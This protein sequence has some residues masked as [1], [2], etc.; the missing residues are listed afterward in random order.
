MQPLDLATLFHKTYERLA[1][2]FGYETRPET[3]EFNPES[4][5][6]K[7]MIAVCTE[8]LK[9]LEVDY[10]LIDDVITD[11]YRDAGDSDTSQACARCNVRRLAEAVG[12]PLENYRLLKEHGPQRFLFRK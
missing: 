7:L 11:I 9:N 3:C 1:P 6:G 8:I 5:N 10:R 12:L 2:S 4:N